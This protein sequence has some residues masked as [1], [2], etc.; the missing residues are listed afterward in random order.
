MGILISSVAKDVYRVIV[1]PSG[2]LIGLAIYIAGS[3][4]AGPELR[5]KF[6]TVITLNRSI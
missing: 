3:A 5:G 2:P 4:S 6:I 1:I